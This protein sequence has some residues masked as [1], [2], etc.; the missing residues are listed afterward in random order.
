MSRLQDCRRLRA[1]HRIAP[2]LSQRVVP[3]RSEVRVRCGGTFQG[4]GARNLGVTQKRSIHTRV[5]AL[6]QLRK[7][8][9]YALFIALGRHQAALLVVEGK[10]RGC[11]L[12]ARISTVRKRDGPRR[13][14][15][16]ARCV[17]KAATPWR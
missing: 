9:L 7:R 17:H 11:A 10:I 16:P 4:T 13:R 15:Q 5:D 6:E 12:R 1:L 3:R 8:A 2:V 14:C